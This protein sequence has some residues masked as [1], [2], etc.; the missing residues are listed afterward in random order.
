M[1][2]A[3]L[4]V[5]GAIHLKSA[6]PCRSNALTFKPSKLIETLQHGEE[7]LVL[8]CTH[9]FH[10]DCLQPWLKIHA[11]CPACRNKVSRVSKWQQARLW[12]SSVA[13][14]TARPA[15]PS[16]NR[17]T[18]TTGTGGTKEM[19]AE[20]VSRRQDNYIVDM[21]TVSSEPS[22]VSGGGEGNV[23]GMG[24]HRRLSYGVG[25]ISED[26]ESSAIVVQAV[27]D[28]PRGEGGDDTVASHLPL[29][30]GELG[31]HEL[32]YERDETGHTQGP[33]IRC[34]LLQYLQ[35]LQSL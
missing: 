13:N 6:M 10:A 19:A 14:H 21:S 23:G 18:R 29:D 26:R 8:L 4:I 5:S 28:E 12:R 34:S 20:G 15:L 27:G 7:L 9:A 30:I 25:D 1:K 35:Y 33:D 17:D 24:L 2:A 32:T 22:C 31:E 3:G 16:P 11:N